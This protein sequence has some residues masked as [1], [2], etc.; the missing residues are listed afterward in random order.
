MTRNRK[1]EHN[2]LNAFGKRN[3]QKTIDVKKQISSLNI[4]NENTK[5]KHENIT[6]IVK[7]ESMDIFEKQ[8]STKKDE[9][10]EN[11]KQ[12]QQYTK[13]HFR[14]NRES[15][16]QE[17]TGKELDQNIDIFEA[18]NEK[19]HEAPAKLKSVMLEMFLLTHPLLC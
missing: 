2:G 14:Q 19:A 15:N 7:T 13:L 5:K 18:V 4:I 12:I 9:L 10:I 6:H 16:D 1:N 8:R 11:E 3:I 17:I